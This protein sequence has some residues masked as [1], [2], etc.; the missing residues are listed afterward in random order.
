MRLFIFFTFCFLQGFSQDSVV[1]R[2]QITTA[3]NQSHSLAEFRGRKIILVILPVTRNA[4][5][6]V[7][8]SVLNSFGL[9]N[10]QRLVVIGIPTVE[11]GYKTDSAM[12][13]NTWYTKLAGAGIYISKGLNSRKASANQDPLF[14]WLTNVSS[15]GHFDDDATGP[16]QVFFIDEYGRLYGEISSS[17]PLTEKLLNKMTQTQ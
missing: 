12:L 6:S 9:L 1:Y 8:L 10:R 3:D 5:D 14:Q 16:G 13:L 7:K 17:A 11:D 2:T 15:N 4:A